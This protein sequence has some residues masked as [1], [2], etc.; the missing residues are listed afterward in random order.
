MAGV[1]EALTA[2]RAELVAAE[3]GRIPGVAG[4]ANPVFIEAGL[5]APGDL[6]DPV[7]DDPELILS[8]MHSGDLGGATGYDVAAHGRHV[9]DLRYR[10]GPRERANVGLRMANGLDVAIR[11]RLFRPET[12]YG[13]GFTLG[14]GQ[15]GALFVQSVGV[16]GGLSRLSYSE[17]RGYDLV[18]KYLVEVSL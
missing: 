9:L 5:V 4:A 1:T 17:A 15:P 14:A 11:K 12:N 6:E 8:L 18:A 2:F 7:E 16:W 13:Y 10:T 3:L